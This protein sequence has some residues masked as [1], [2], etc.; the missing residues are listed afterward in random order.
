[1]TTSVESHFQFSRLIITLPL[2]NDDHVNSIRV[3]VQ[4]FLVPHQ[5]QNSKLKIWPDHTCRRN[6]SYQFG[7]NYKPILILPVS[8]RADFV[9]NFAIFT[10]YCPPENFL[11]NLIWKI[12]QFNDHF[13]HEKSNIIHLAIF[14]FITNDHHYTS[15]PPVTITFTGTTTSHTTASD[16]TIKSLANNKHQKIVQSLSYSYTCST[17][18]PVSNALGELSRISSTLKLNPLTSNTSFTKYL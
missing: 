7:I 17:I 1:M 4:K 2:P 11:L 13:R 18:L 12:S 8:S 10:Y 6:L 5:R 3:I 16:T 14:F 15:L 9:H